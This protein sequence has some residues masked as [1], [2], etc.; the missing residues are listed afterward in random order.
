MTLGGFAGNIAGY[1]YTTTL[2]LN[3][4]SSTKNLLQ[5]VLT[6]GSM[7]PKYTPKGI[8]EANRR[9]LKYASLRSSGE[10]AETAWEKAF[11]EFHA[12]KLDPSPLTEKLLKGSLEDAWMTAT[13]HVG[14]GTT[15]SQKAQDIMLS[16]FSASERYNRIVAFHTSLARQAAEKAAGI[17]DIQFGTHGHGMLVEDPTG[18]LVL[19]EAAERAREFVKFTQFPAGLGQTPYILQN[20]PAPFRQFMHFPLRYIDFLI[21][22]TKMGVEQG[23]NWG[24]VGRTMAGA[25]AAYEL[26]QG[27]LDVDLSAGLV[28]GALPLPMGPDAPFYPFP[29]VPP[30]LGLMGAGVAALQSG[31]MQPLTQQLPVVIPSGVALARAQ[32]YLYP[33]IPQGARKILASEYADYPTR[34]ADG[35][36]PLYTS[37]GVLKGYHTPMQLIGRAM[38]LGAMSTEKERDLMEYLMKQRDIIR[39]YRREY[40]EAIVSNDYHK[41][42]KVQKEFQRHFPE[43]GPIVIHQRDLDAI[44]LRREIPRLERVMDTIPEQYRPFYGRMVGEILAGEAQRL[45][46]VDPALL[47]APRTTATRRRQMQQVSRGVR[48][49]GMLGVG[50]PRLPSLQSPSLNPLGSP[51]AALGIR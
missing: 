15:L 22:S 39:E 28:T 27:L 9:V 11:P 20:I 1:F 5:T 13:R 33:F 21:S 49:G 31:S 50:L 32:R 16:L 8:A 7:D 14:A 44:R 12:A 24:T 40:L 42:E 36:I 18:Q 2:G 34:T 45:M 30:T 35:R 6:T 43:L 46:G 19:S 10:L 3:P 48:R 37:Q 4:A 17:A 25:A 38:G 26:G 29:L 23:R 51:G 41:A 47:M